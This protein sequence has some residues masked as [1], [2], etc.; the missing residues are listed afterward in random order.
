MP[1]FADIMSG[2]VDVS[3]LEERHPQGWLGQVRL[4]PRDP[5]TISD[6]GWHQD[7]RPEGETR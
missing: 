2:R 3:R 4:D 7:D 5:S 6:R 1:S